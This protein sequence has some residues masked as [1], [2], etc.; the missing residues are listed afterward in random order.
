[1]NAP[2]SAHSIVE[3]MDAV[4]RC[5][6]PGLV[7]KIA[8]KATNP[9]ATAFPATTGQK[10]WLSSAGSDPGRKSVSA[11]HNSLKVTQPA[12]NADL[13]FASDLIAIDFPPNH[14]K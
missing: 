9:I 5:A 14:P 3:M 13:S 8:I 6:L 12:A 7:R 1:V 2:I 10:K 4:A 11:S